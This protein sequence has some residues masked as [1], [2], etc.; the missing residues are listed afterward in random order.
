MDFIENIE[1]IRFAEPF[2]LI[3]VFLIPLIFFIQKK[4]KLSNPTLLFSSTDRF[5]KKR[6]QTTKIDLFFF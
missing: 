3:L 6:N 1:K 2:W 5:K 4:L